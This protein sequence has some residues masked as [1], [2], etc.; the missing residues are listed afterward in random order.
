MSAERLVEAPAAC[1]GSPA[2]RVVT[3]HQRTTRASSVGAASAGDHDLQHGRAAGGL[4]S[5]VAWPPLRPVVWHTRP[6]GL[7]RTTRF[8]PLPA[9]ARR[10]SVMR[11]GAGGVK[12]LAPSA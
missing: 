7:G 11:A 5:T 9:N 2:A 3:G 6:V 12:A 10:V 8:A 1:A 4:V